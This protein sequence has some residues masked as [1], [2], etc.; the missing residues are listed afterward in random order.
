MT[1]SFQQFQGSSLGF[2]TS[3]TNYLQTEVDM[4]EA[5][6]KQID[7]NTKQMNDHFDRLIKM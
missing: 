4:T 7:E 1:N 3:Q 2:P 6:N 5:V